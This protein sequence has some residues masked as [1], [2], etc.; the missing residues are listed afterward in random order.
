MSLTPQPRVVSPVSS[1]S[2]TP[3]ARPASPISRSSSQSVPAATQRAA[4][5]TRSAAPYRPGFQPKGLYRPRT[6]EFLETRRTTSDVGR[7]ERTRLE[8]R[9]EKLISLH[10]PHPDKVKEKEAA[11]GRPAAAQNRRASSFFDIDISSLKGKSASELWRGVVQSQA[12][13]KNDTR[14]MWFRNSCRRFLIDA[15]VE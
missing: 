4:T 13:G 11:N 14:C 5:P 2:S 3:A 7:V 8:R 10:F 9:L 1:A 15:S 12:N 6:D